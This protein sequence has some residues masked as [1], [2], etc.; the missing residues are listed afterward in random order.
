MSNIK[1]DKFMRYRPV[2]KADVEPLLTRS[3]ASGKPLAG[4]RKVTAD[5]MFESLQTTAQLTLTMKAD[6]TI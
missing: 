4:V 5:R 2:P 6:V 1:N 3:S